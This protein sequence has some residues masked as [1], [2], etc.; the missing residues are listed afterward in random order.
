[1]KTAG[2]CARNTWTTSSSVRGKVMDK[3]FKELERRAK[4]HPLYETRLRHNVQDAR[5]DLER[6]P[7]LAHRILGDLETVIESYEN[8]WEDEY[9]D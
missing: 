8:D 5:E 2:I 4:K 9:E 3:R 1:M 7:R 6:Y